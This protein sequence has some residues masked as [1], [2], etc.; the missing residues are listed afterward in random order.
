MSW[1]LNPAW[2]ALI[3]SIIALGVSVISLWHGRRTTRATAHRSLIDHA[4]GINETILRYNVKGPFAHRLGIPDDQVEAFSAK[5]VLLL[6][7]MNLLREVYENRDILGEKVVFSHLDWAK[8]ILLPWIEADKHLIAAWK[9]TRDSRDLFE[10][11]FLEWLDPY[12]PTS[13]MKRIRQTIKVDGQ[14]CWT[15]FDTGVRNTYVI[16][17]V[18]HVLK[19]STMPRVFR[20]VLG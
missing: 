14:E 19:T 11:E 3:A 1:Y 10:A 20:T 7:Q 16:P 9:L 8:T 18:A 15:L 2:W 4:L 6:Q 5:A 17:S 12:F 13:G